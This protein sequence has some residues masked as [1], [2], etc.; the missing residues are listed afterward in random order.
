L[1]TARS[2]TVVALEQTH[3]IYMS[4]TAYLELIDPYLSVILDDKILFFSKTPLF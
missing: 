4:E 1:D 2:S 3:L